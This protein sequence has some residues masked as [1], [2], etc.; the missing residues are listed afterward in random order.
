MGME[1]KIEKKKSTK[2]RKAPILPRLGIYIDF[3]GR[4]IV[5]RQIPV[6]ETALNLH[7]RGLSMTNLLKITMEQFAEIQFPKTKKKVDIVET[8]AKTISVKTKKK[9]SN[10]IKSKNKS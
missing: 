3:C 10:L 6:L 2:T 7:E 5:Y 9:R 1:L 8:S 4:E